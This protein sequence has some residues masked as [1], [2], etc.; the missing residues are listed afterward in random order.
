[1]AECEDKNTKLIQNVEKLSDRNDNLV[2]EIQ[3][4]EKEYSDLKRENYNLVLQLEEQRD[5]V[6]RIEDKFRK[7]ES[8]N[9]QDFMDV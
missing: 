7:L 9:V 3:T 1:L 6:D 2:K 5:I 4:I 8:A